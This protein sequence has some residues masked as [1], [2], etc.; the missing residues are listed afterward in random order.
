[1]WN[2]LSGGS[3]GGTELSVA[4]VASTVNQYVGVAVAIVLGLLAAVVVFYAIYIG[5]RMAKAEDDAKRKE[6]K[7]HLIYAILGVVAIALIIVVLQAV[8]P[9]LSPSIDEDIT[10]I[11]GLDEVMIAINEFLQAAMQLIAA[12]ATMFAVWIGWKFISAETDEKRKNAKMQLI[13]TC[14]GVIGVVLLV[15]IA[16]AILGGLSVITIDNP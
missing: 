16:G 14:L 11:E 10:D 6:A 5:F 7:G 9:L 13:Y 8:L 1:M 15:V 2:L 12:L 3:G 4:D